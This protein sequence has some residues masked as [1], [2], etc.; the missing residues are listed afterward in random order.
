[1]DF[2]YNTG[3]WDQRLDQKR[4]AQDL[5]LTKVHEPQARHW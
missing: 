3:G 2:S 5:L 1:M 4:I